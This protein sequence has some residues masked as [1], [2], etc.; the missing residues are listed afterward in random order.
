MPYHLFKCS[1]CIPE[2][3]KHAVVKGPGEDLTRCPSSWIP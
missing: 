3:E 1:E 2:R